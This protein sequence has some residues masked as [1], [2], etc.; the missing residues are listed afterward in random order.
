LKT[1]IGADLLRSC[2][3]FAPDIPPA[4]LLGPDLNVTAD[5]IGS[6]DLGRLRFY[7]LLF[8]VR[9]NRPFQGHHAILHNDFDVVGIRG[10]RFVLRQ[11]APDLLGKLAI[12]GTIF[13]LVCGRSKNMNSESQPEWMDLKALQCYACISERA[14]RQ[15]IHCPGNSL[16]T[17][18]TST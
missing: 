2:H 1:V 14:L 15:E 16:R 5:L 8:A 7:G 18:C 9:V 6:G 3:C 17:Q 13:L 11:R 12:V 10:Q 4:K